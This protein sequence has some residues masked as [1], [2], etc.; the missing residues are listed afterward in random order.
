M[1]LEAASRKCG[2]SFI[3]LGYTSFS[4]AKKHNSSL[5]RHSMTLQAEV[6]I[7]QDHGQWPKHGRLQQ[8]L[9]PLEY[10]GLRH[11]RQREP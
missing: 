6:H 11:S 9:L 10:R 2:W 8:V 1:L 4:E 5:R 3:C 7:E